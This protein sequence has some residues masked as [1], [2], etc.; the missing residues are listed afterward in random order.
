MAKPSDPGTGFGLPPADTGNLA[1]NWISGALL[2]LTHFERRFDPFFRPAFD[3]L[4]RDRLSTLI[5]ALI[6]RTRKTEGLQIAEERPQPNEQ[7]HLDDIIATFSAQ[8]HR[9]WNPG[10]FE[11]GGNTKTHGIVRAEFI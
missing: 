9:L 2:C 3:A 7:A 11:R 5:T 10:H 1:L 6:N 4:L 8:L